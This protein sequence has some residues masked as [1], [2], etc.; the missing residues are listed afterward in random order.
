MV[1]DETFLRRVSID[2]IG[3]QPTPAERGAFVADLAPDK[4][5]KQV[6]ALMGRPE[7][8]DWWTLKWG[9]FFKTRGIRRAIQ[10]FTRSGSG[11]DR[12]WR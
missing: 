3:L 2:L 11:F 9:I 10:R 7:F 6:E 5:A 1:E 12:R 8:I 4:R